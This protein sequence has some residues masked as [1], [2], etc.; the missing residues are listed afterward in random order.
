MRSDEFYM[1]L[2]WL[3]LCQTNI[4]AYHWYSD[5]LRRSLISPDLDM[6]LFY[7]WHHV[8]HKHYVYTIIKTCIP[9]RA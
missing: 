3:G 2:Q 7:D 4:Q 1:K 9:L 8:M 5:I 6:L